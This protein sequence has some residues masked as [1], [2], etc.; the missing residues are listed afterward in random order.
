[1]QSSISVLRGPPAVRHSTSV[2]PK[3]A[4]PQ[5]RPLAPLRATNYKASGRVQRSLAGWRRRQAHRRRRRSDSCSV[6]LPRAAPWPLLALSA[7]GASCQASVGWGAAPRSPPPPPACRHP[8]RLL[9][10]HARSGPKLLPQVTFRFP[11]GEEQT[12]E[13]SCAGFGVG[14]SSR[15]A[16]ASHDRAGSCRRHLLCALR[17]AS[18][19]CL[20]YCLSSQTRTPSRCPTTRSSS[21]RVRC[22]ALRSAPLADAPL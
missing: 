4:R 21:M 11:E 22:T 14:W 19:S 3:A 16:A 5:A 17:V 13:V 15:G 7:L 1:M 6:C 20:P 9:P 2:R 18:P 12:I 8:A 10:A